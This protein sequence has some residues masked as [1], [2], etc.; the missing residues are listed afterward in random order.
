MA[1]FAKRKK[2]P[3]E[4]A[5]QLLAAILRRI[6]AGDGKKA[7]DLLRRAQFKGVPAERTGPLFH[8]A[9]ALRARELEAR[10]FADQAAAMREASERYPASFGDLPVSAENLVHLLRSQGDRECFA[11]Y[12][13]YLD[14]NPPHPEAER[15]LANR[16]VLKRC[17]AHLA[18]LSE[19]S[20]FRRDATR[21]LAALPA[22][23]Q[24]QWGRACEFLEALPGDSGFRDWQ[25]FAEAMDAYLRMEPDDLGRALGRLRPDFPLRASVKALRS[26]LK[27]RTGS[28]G[29]AVAELLG[30]RAAH[31]A[32]TG[33]KLRKA[34]RFSAVPGQLVQ[35]IKDFAAA[36]D[37]LEPVETRLDLARALAV[38]VRDGQLDFACFLA[39]VERLTPSERAASQFLLAIVQSLGQTDELLPVAEIPGFLDWLEREFGDPEARAVARASVLQRLAQSIRRSE[40]VHFNLDDLTCLGALAGKPDL[41][42]DPKYEGNVLAVAAALARK[43]LETDP[44]NAEGHRQLIEI[45]RER[46]EGTNAELIQ[47]YENYGEALPQ[48]PEPWIKLA[49]LRMRGKAYRK[50]DAAL[51]R[52]EQCEGRTARVLELRALAS[53]VAAQRNLRGGRTELAA[54]DLGMAAS[55]KAPRAEPVR[56]AWQAFLGFEQQGR[57]D[58]LGAFEAALR[59]RPPALRAHAL[60]VAHEACGKPGTRFDAP[61]RAARRLIR[62]AE[63]AVAVACRE[64]PGSLV[65][66]VVPLPNVFASVTDPKAVPANLP[67]GWLPVLEATPARSLIDVLR[68]AV[69]FGACVPART[70]AAA[71]LRRAGDGTYRRILFLYVAALRYLL[72]EDLDGR[73]LQRLKDSIPPEEQKPVRAAAEQLSQALDRYFMPMLA[74]SLQSFD[75]DLL[76]LPRGLF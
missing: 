18:E 36:V 16:L 49:E 25:A 12:A 53:L 29:G 59:G 2:R 19:A 68:L 14:A 63:D 21:I 23:D 52:A 58:L 24:G 28:V 74:D 62:R 6:G 67:G 38:A 46:R 31:V 44:S 32:A 10:G 69:E 22:M 30:V 48:D 70:V 27:P 50:A 34:V 26:A 42:T 60:I 57:R 72:R 47:A 15:G 4:S 3:P 11:T 17:E 75:F 43:G 45:L 65:P 13:K 5:G 9:Y 66:L 33:H 71:R 73:R 64:D 56:L 1:R 76:D 61:A 41:A 20:A 51:E 7:I 8:R 39:V 54:R 37:P 40:W 55:R 35:A